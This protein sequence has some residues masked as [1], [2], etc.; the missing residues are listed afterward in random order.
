MLDKD[1]IPVASR[2]K[3]LYLSFSFFLIAI[4]L[5]CKCKYKYN[6]LNEVVVLVQGGEAC[7]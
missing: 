3:L 7:V 5:R 1:E 4:E 2:C 6:T